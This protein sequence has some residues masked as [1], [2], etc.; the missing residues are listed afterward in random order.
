MH[1]H[2]Q[3]LVIVDAVADDAG[4][5]KGKLA[6]ESNMDSRNLLL[7]GCSSNVGQL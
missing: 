7:I 2:G 5:F 3:I 6:G 1:F 4:L